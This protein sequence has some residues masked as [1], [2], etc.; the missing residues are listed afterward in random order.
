MSSKSNVRGFVGQNVT[1]K[2][3]TMMII[4][5]RLKPILPY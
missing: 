5:V 2:T 4:P 1:I 3:I